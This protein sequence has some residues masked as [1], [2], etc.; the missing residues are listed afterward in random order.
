MRRT[1]IKS[2]HN[3]IGMNEDQFQ[4]RLFQWAHN[5]YPQLRKLLFHVP[6]GGKRSKR[7]SNKFKA[8][9]VVAG[10]P[11]LVLLWKGRLYGFELK[12]EKGKQSDEQAE[13]ENKWSEHHAEYYLIRDEQVFKT[14]IQNIIS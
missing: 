4:A 1:G 10:I 6:N 14:L 7:E 11:D 12:A 5:T 3:C 13:A 8:M 9:G 2:P